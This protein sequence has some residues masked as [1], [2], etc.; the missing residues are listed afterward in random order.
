GRTR[1]RARPAAGARGAPMPMHPGDR[2]R[3]LSVRA[4]LRAA[5]RTGAAPADVLRIRPPLPDVACDVVLCLD[6]SASMEGAAVAPL[7]R[8]LIEALTRDTHR[9]GM[10][11]FAS[12]TTELCGLTRDPAVLRAAATAYEP[13]NP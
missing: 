6:V 11:V 2:H 7:A 10:V 9:V 3:D 13:A 12:G 1:S 4:T 8:S 5:A